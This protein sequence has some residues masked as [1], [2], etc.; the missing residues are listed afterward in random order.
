MFCHRFVNDR[1][2]GGM[3]IFGIAARLIT[4]TIYAL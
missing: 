3:A 1:V 4:S 2:C